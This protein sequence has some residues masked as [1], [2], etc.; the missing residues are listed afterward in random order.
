M[1]AKLGA[2]IL[3]SPAAFTKATGEAH[4]HV[5]QRARAIEHGCY[6]IAPCQYGELVGG[7]Q[8]FGHSLIIDPWGKILADAGNGEGFIIADIDI[9]EADRARMRIPTLSHDREFF[10]INK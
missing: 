8:C 4:W 10:P 9:S 6:V 7:G 1:L 2:K 3:A 5:L